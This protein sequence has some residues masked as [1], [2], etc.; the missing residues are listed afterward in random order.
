MKSQFALMK[1][2]AL[3]KIGIIIGNDTVSYILQSIF[4]TR[5][6]GLFSVTI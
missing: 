2:M 3:L 6:V 5:R 4:R 1:G